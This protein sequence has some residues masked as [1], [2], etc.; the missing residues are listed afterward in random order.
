MPNVGPHTFRGTTAEWPRCSDSALPSR[1]KRLVISGGHIALID[2]EALPVERMDY[3]TSIPSGASP[4]H[5]TG[6]EKPLGLEFST[7]TIPTI[8]RVH[9]ETTPRLWPFGFSPR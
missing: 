6:D 8:T 3:R 5:I 4:A 7:P 2:E 1:G 9:I